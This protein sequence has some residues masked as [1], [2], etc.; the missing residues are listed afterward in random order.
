MKKVFVY[1]IPLI[2]SIT[3]AQPK[4]PTSTTLKLSLQ[5]TEGTNGCAVVWNSK[6]NL[7][8]SII[9]G[10]TVFPIDIFTATG[11]WKSSVE[12]GVD[13]RGLWYNTKSGT[14]GGRS[15]DGDFVE[16]SLSDSGVPENFT[17][18]AST[19]IDGQSVATFGAKGTIYIY[20]EG[21]IVK[22]SSK[23][24]K[25]G[26]IRLP[27]DFNPDDYNM[28]SMGYTFVKNYELVLVNNA[29]STFDFYNLKGKRTGSVKLPNGAPYAE[30]FRFSFAN[31]I[32]WLFDAD[33]RTWNG[34][35]I[36]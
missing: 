1:I 15:L 24:K 32:A 19:D 28:Y 3:F 17:T 27:D 26:T 13:N 10:N 34:Y 33:T 35:K 14:L 20:Q 36:F 9:A 5:S 16:W 8:Y 6:Q 18:V 30:N 7:Y 23:G 4:T 21:I 12:S 31:K 22:Y 29:N 25:T 11:K 2:S